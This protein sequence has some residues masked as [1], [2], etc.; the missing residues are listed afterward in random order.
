MPEWLRALMGETAAP[1]L[2][3]AA[4][5]LIGACLLGYLLGS[6]PFGVLVTRLA[7]LGDLRS[8]GSGNIGATNVLRTGS[9]KAAAAVLLL[10]GLKGVAAVL[11]AGALAGRD[12]AALAALFAVLGHCFPVWLRFRGG[13]GVATAL[14][15]LLALAPLAGVGACLLWLAMAF[16]FRI[17]SL[18]A[19]VAIALTPALVYAVGRPEAVIPIA[20]AAAVVFARHH[21][22]IAR[23]LAGTEP[24]IGKKG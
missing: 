23:L 8:I 6:I 3:E 4:P 16:A 12:A 10:D 5:W 19:L 18:S 11:I 1:G 22:N 15:V 17:S 24:K 9:K 2:D 21:A 20:I 7:G 14:G 13:K